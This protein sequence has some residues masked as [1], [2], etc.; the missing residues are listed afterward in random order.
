MLVV[1]RVLAARMMADRIRDASTEY[2]ADTVDG[3]LKRV[4]FP[5][6]AFAFLTLLQ[7]SSGLLLE[8]ET[9]RWS[10]AHLTFQEYFTAAS[11]VSGVAPPGNWRALAG[12]A[13]WHETL[14]LYSAL[15]DAT[16]ILTACLEDGGIAALALAA[17]CVDEA[18]EAD[19]A[20]A[21]AVLD[22]V[23]A[24]LGSPLRPRRQLAA[25]VRLSRRLKTLQ[26]I[27]DSREID[28]ILITWA[29]Y[30]LFLDAIAPSGS[31][32]QPDHWFRNDYDPVMAQQPAVGVRAQDGKAF[33][34]WLSRR[35]GTPA[36][37][38][39]PRWHELAEFPSPSSE[40][41]WFEEP[42]SFGVLPVIDEEPLRRYLEDNSTLPVA[43]S[44]EMSE[45][46]TLDVGRAALHVSRAVDLDL[47]LDLADALGFSVTVGRSMA[48]DAAKTLNGLVDRSLRTD[49]SRDNR[50]RARY[51][52]GFLTRYLKRMLDQD[53]DHIAERIQAGD[54]AG[55][56]KAVDLYGVSRLAGQDLRA[57]HILRAADLLRTMLRAA[58]PTS[59]HPRTGQRKYIAKLLELCH[60]GAEERRGVQLRRT[61]R[62]LVSDDPRDEELLVP[63][64]RWLLMI[65][66]VESGAVPAAGGIRVV[67]EFKT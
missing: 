12:D 16:P 3:P 36:K 59:E 40:P 23:I 55:A 50:E 53:R 35:S 18:R 42:G 58:D 49:W 19:P 63:F 37:Y 48:L 8:R 30:Q 28:P 9:D 56:V 33:C 47:V 15:G 14:R 38:R 66:G 4:G 52:G 64:H 60:R 43:S 13:W 62:R 20:V 46:W 65:A 61:L 31:T 45:I 41:A 27:D 5:R 6:D 44:A 54:W 32:R 24:D 34:E 67:R 1:L 21:N 17:D 39:L 26:R 51:V 11:W 29:E 10:F 57:Q 7:S 2:V 22:R 25:E